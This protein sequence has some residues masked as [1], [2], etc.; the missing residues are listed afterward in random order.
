MKYEK[1]YYRY[2]DA[3]K[4][5]ML[6]QKNKTQMLMTLELSPIECEKEH[7][8]CLQLGALSVSLYQVVPIPEGEGS[9]PVAHFCPILF[10]FAS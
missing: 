3:Y 5:K 4:C 9:H 10:L 1:E 2:L 8:V 7:S 6:T